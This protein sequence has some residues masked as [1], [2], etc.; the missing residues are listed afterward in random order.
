MRSI[1][2]SPRVRVVQKCGQTRACISE[3]I[4]EQ[5]ARESCSA[6]RSEM[7]SIVASPRV[8]RFSHSMR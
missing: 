7:R 3:R 6:M 5:F 2:A 8:S 1:A 4:S